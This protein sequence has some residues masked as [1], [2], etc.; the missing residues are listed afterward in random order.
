[1]ILLPVEKQLLK[2]KLYQK[3]ALQNVAVISVVASVF[4]FSHEL[5]F[6]A[7]NEQKTTD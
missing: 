6:D 7:A 5:F 3:V 4:F 2:Q 1:M